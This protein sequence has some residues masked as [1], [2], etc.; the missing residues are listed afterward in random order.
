MNVMISY[1]HVDEESAKKLHDSLSQ[2]SNIEPWIDLRDL[3]PGARW[4]EELMWAIQRSDVIVILLSEAGLSKSGYFQWE[5]RRAIEKT[6]LSPRGKIVLI[7]VRLDDCDPQ[8]NELKEL[9]IVDFFP[10]WG[11]GLR[12][13]LLALSETK[14]QKATGIIDEILSTLPEIY[15]EN[16]IDSRTDFETHLIATRNF[17]RFNLMH[18]DLSELDLSQASFVGANLVGTSLRRCD[19][20]GSDFEYANIERVDLSESNVSETRFVNSNLWG[21]NF[22]EIKELESV[23]VTDSNIFGVQDVKDD[24]I[25]SWESVGCF[26]AHMYNE[27]FVHIRNSQDV[28]KEKIVSCFAWLNHGYFRLLLDPKT[29]VPIEMLIEVCNYFGSD[30]ICVTEISRLAPQF[31]YATESLTQAYSE[32]KALQKVMKRCVQVSMERAKRNGVWGEKRH[33]HIREAIERRNR[34]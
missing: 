23:V 6:E 22:K 11:A 18:L 9:H 7:P 14:L 21:A 17:N 19:L 30:N 8:Y 2:E 16:S 3:L 28:S 24:I 27:F 34:R 26:K 12:K 20:S 33:K 4:K 10:D 13:L 31:H 5:I 25:H 15:N 29:P 32:N 1:S